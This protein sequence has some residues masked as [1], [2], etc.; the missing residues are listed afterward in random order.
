MLCFR[1]MAYALAQ[2][3]NRPD[4]GLNA[5]QR[6][7]AIV[8]ESEPGQKTVEV[9]CAKAVLGS[10]F[11]SVGDCASAIREY[12]C[13]LLC[14]MLYNWREYVYCDNRDTGRCW[15]SWRL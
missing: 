15:I 5:A 1:Q 13:V 2:G 4:L 6:A 3:S 11:H 9:A 10:A 14:V 7:V 8:V 12:R